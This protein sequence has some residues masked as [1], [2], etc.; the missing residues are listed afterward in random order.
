MK[1][2]ENKEFIDYEV[3]KDFISGYSLD[4]KR[5]FIILT[6]IHTDLLHHLFY[7]D[8]LIPEIKNKAPGNEYK[9][10]LFQK[11]FIGLISTM[12]EAIKYLKRTNKA[13]SIT[14]EMESFDSLLEKVRNNLGYHYSYENH[15]KALIGN[16]FDIYNSNNE[17]GLVVLLCKESNINIF[18]DV[19]ELK[20]RLIYFIT[21]NP[22]WIDEC[23]D[24]PASY[25][26]AK[27]QEIED[28]PE[29]FDDWFNDF[30]SKTV[31]TAKSIDS[32]CAK[33]LNSLM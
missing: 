18:T 16:V 9:R 11:N 22:N 6:S 23:S 8:E 28:N 12:H 21:H 7:F 27:M 33:F 24:N 10:Y 13:E 4:Q 26:K 29:V 3:S 2:I 15:F 19:S 25:I 5:D 14:S 17:N 30:L 31:S 1:Y 20:W 32:I